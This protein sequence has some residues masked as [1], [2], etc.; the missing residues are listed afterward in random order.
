MG[1]IRTDP[2]FITALKPNRLKCDPFIVADMETVIVHNVH[3]P[4]AAGL[5]VVHP[6][7]DVAAMDDL[8]YTSFTEDYQFIIPTFEER[9]IKMLVDF[10]NRIAALGSPIDGVQTVYFHNFS[11]FDGILLMKFLVTHMG[12]YK[13]KPLMRNNTLYQ[14]SVYSQ[15]KKGKTKLLFKLRD[16]YTL[17][18][19]S[20]DTLA[21]TLCPHLG[22]KGSIAHDE[23]KVS[24]LQENRATLLDYMKQDIRLLG[25]VMLRAQDI[26]W[27][28]Y[29]VDIVEC[30]TLSS[31]AMRIFRIKYYDHKGCPIYIPSSN[32]DAFIRRGYYGGHAD[33]YKP[34]G[35]NL[36]YYDVNSLY[37]FI[38]KTFAMPG[39]KPVWHGNLEGLELD[40]MCGFIEA[41]VV[42]PSTITRPFLPYKNRKKT[43]LFPIGQFVGVYYSEELKYARDLGYE[44]LPLRG[45]LFEKMSSPFESFV[46]DI[47][48][49]RQEAKKCGDDAMAYVYKILMNSLYGRFGINPEC[50]ITEVCQKA[51]YEDLIQRNN[52]ISGNKLSDHYYLVSYH[53]H[54][55]HDDNSSDFK[56]P[57]NSAVQ[58]SAAITACARIH[59]YKYI[60]RPDCYYTDTDSAILGNPLPEDE[61]S[62]TVLG[63]LKEEHIVKNAYFLAP[64]CYSL[65]T[66]TGDVIIK[67]KGIANELIDYEWFVSQY[68]DLSRIKKG[69]VESSFRIDWHTLQIA[70][71]YVNVNLGIQVDNKRVPV[72]DENKQWIDTEPKYILDIGGEDSTILQYELKKLKHQNA[73]MQSE[74]DILKSNVKERDQRV[75]RMES[76][77]AQLRL[78][79]H[80]KTKHMADLNNNI[81]RLESIINS[82]RVPII[83]NSTD[84][85]PED[86]VKHPPTVSKEGSNY[87]AKDST[88]MTPKYNA[89]IDGYKTPKRK[90]RRK[91]R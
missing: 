45:Y 13:I 25:G 74:M 81:D 32:Q 23:V 71:K 83:S 57:T 22:P 88:S 42:C 11:R 31:L 14:L 86:A 9:S 2:Q 58:I 52:F 8:I 75:A 79:D 44:I 36:Y 19:N 53:S 55:G 33:T 90:K 76:E 72:Y 61:I 48:A 60:S 80:E 7:D 1:K 29:N 89:T 10:I 18:P 35:E 78:K 91:K 87:N 16:S 82:L 3:V 68:A 65:L 51:R 40:N 37:P 26:Y 47:F 59:M 17:L 64:K 39:G 50:T 5:L 43:L 70:K 85:H 28:Q 34:Y 62:S 38:M 56:L 46:S 67:H 69:V 12:D 41:Y 15:D 77:M 73:C 49:S 30:L 4:Y 24:S 27:T 21:K 6:G 66:N 84:K 20:L 63:K 54:T